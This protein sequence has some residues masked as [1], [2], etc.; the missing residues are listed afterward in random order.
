[1]RAWRARAPG[2]P[3]DVLVLAEV[4]ARRGAAGLQRLADGDMLGRIVFVR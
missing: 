2:E 4:R 3:R 1:M